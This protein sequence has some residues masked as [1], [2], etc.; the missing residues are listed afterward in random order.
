MH[1]RRVHPR[2]AIS[3]GLA[4]SITELSRE[5][6]RVVGVLI[7]RNGQVE[8]VG[9]GNATRL[10]LPDI[11]RARA[12]SSRLRG[13]R[14]VLSELS[15]GKKPVK[16]RADLHTDLQKLQLDGVI[17][18]AALEGGFVGPVAS[19]QLLPQNDSDQRT[20]M[21]RYPKVQTLAEEDFAAE[22]QALEDELQRSTGQGKDVRRSKAKGPRAVL[23][24]V[25]TQKRDFAQRSMDELHQL[26]LAAGAQVVEEIVQLRRSIDPRSLVGKGKL[27]DIC[28]RSL[29]LGADFLIFDGELSPTQLKNITDAT[30]QRVLDRSMLIL[31]IFAQRARSLDGKVQVE[32]AQ[33]RYSLPRLA[34]RQTGL[35]RLTGGIGG[36]GPGETR[37]EVDRRRAKD[38]I[39]RLEREVDSLAKGRKVR[40]KR[41]KQRHLPIISIV[42]YT[43]AGKSTLLNALTKSEV[44]VEDALFATLDPTSRRLRFPREREVIITD[45]V[46]FIRELPKDLVAAFRATLEELDDADLLWHVIDA[47]DPQVIEQV[48]AVEK[49]LEDLGIA[50]KA[51]LLVLNKADLAAELQ[52]AVRARGFNATVV[53]ALTGAGL[54]K[55]LNRSADIL[56]QEE[57]LPQAQKWAKEPAVVVKPP[58][59]ADF[60]YLFQ[61][62]P[63]EDGT[64]DPSAQAQT[65]AQL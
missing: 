37:L 62:D 33:L 15:D 22:I 44:F 52:T 39:R 27:E 50:D 43:N 56:W 34:L 19:L 48:A 10:Y 12:G 51:R 2:L 53:S 61:Q 45:T 60:S 36:R 26:A 28:L 59:A 13:L 4:R 9:V 31:D 58:S 54:E 42:G 5:I 1:A 20:R 49:T 46:G 47:S 41:R 23:V 8:R 14:L 30:D 24:G 7:N 11:G 3:P 21:Q 18:L 55:L 32:L 38:R 17:V 25:Y 57:V 65:E 16:V 64:A 35:S 63:A 29:H 6:G 40:R